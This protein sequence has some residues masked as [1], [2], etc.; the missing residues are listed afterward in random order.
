MFIAH[1]CPAI[2]LV[3]SLPL[4]VLDTC[5]G[6]SEV[7]VTEANPGPSV[8]PLPVASACHPGPIGLSGS[9]RVSKKLVKVAI[10]F[11]I[12]IP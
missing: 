2:D 1:L 9:G 4:F 11:S 7:K 6:A 5:I 12:G 3:N 8:P 10:Y